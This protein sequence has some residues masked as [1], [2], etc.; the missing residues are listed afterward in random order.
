MKQTLTK[1]LSVGLLLSALTA[2]SSDTA[3]TTSSTSTT[4]ESTSSVES[5]SNNGNEVSEN[6]YPVTIQNIN[7]AGEEIDIVFEQAPERVLAVYQGTIETM[8]ALG[9]EDRVIA[10]YGLD[11]EVKPEWE[12]AFA[13]MNYDESV[14]AP[15]LET[16]MAMEPDF[17]FSWGSLFAD[18]KLGD[19][20]TWMA[21]GTN[22]YIA[23]NSHSYFKPNTLQNEYDTLLNMG[24]IFNV[25]DK[26]QAIVDEMKEEIEKTIVL[27]QGQETQRVLAVEF[28]A[29]GSIDNYSTSTIVG[30]MVE[31]LG[32]ELLLTDS[33]SL[34]KE[35][36]LAED[37]DVIFVIYMPK[38]EENG[39][40]NIYLDEAFSSL[41]AVAEERVYGVM[42]GDTYASAVRT[43]DGIKTIS[44]GLYPELT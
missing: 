28:R 35:D 21:R 44:A 39:A 6:H 8:I 30:N 43:L 34:L 1:I 41:T 10:C 23:A 27:T 5:T 40:D 38:G 11:N 24:K 37:P 7:Y 42:L 16:T 31:S 25:E 22:C 13:K 2:C 3:T 19:V 18:T 9:L 12:D 32:G 20:E 36:I 15:D 14:F 29:N 26:A 4:S 17:I 33:A